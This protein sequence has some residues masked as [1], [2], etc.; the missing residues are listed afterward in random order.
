ME[1]PSLIYDW[2]EVTQDFQ[3]SSIESVELDDETLRDGLQNP[4]VV[5]PPISEKI[6]LLHYMDQLGITTADI[7][8]PGAGPRAVDAVT[9][10]AQ[11]VVDSKLSIDVNCAARTVLADVRPIV[12]IS[13]K[14]GIAIEACTF[15]GSS[16]I[17]QYAEDWTL[18]KM[19]RVTEESV[20]F[21]VRE[22]LP[23]MM[24]TE[25]TTRAHPDV[26]KELYSKAIEWGARRLCIADTVG[27]ATPAGVRALVRFVI[28]EIVEPSGESVGVDWHG[29][30]DR[31]LGLAN[32][33]AAIEAGATR[34]HGTALGIGERSGNTEMDMILVN[35]KLL[36]AH[37]ADLSVLPEYCELVAEACQIPLVH[38]Y[39]VIGADA[40]RTATGVHAAAIVKAHAKGDEWLADR[41]YSA[42]PASMVGRKQVIEIGPM[43]G[44][45]NVKFWL[46]ANGY[47][48]E[49]E[50]LCARI[51]QAA[52]KTD[53]TLT[54][55]ELEVLCKMG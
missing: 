18:A 51:F 31:G 7:G 48:P 49:D 32:T 41:I 55:G 14:V 46:R 4:S 42:V 30:R 26:L 12:D 3:W 43:S 20:T 13:Q 10:L 39:P 44:L 36:G 37:D 38:S 8:L 24:V 25:D 53:R 28:E 27:H 45:S 35:L 9:A 5:D 15:I 54:K 2:N 33:I 16:P 47:N 17:R 6:R 40:F 21:A 19:L 23:V 11:E 50:E 34:V 52:K 29:H 1:E 22:G